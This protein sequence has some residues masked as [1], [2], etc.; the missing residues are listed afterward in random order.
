V[1][2]DWNGDGADGM[3]V[4]RP[5]SAAWQL[6]NVARSGGLDLQFTYDGS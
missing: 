4:P 5:S 3:D 1:V 2:G 6:R